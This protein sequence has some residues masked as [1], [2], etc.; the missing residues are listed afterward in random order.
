MRRL[1][2]RG[3]LA[4][5]AMMLMVA[6]ACSKDDVQPDPAPTSTGS[7]ED[8]TVPEVPDEPVE[9][10]MGVA[11]TLAEAQAGDFTVTYDLFR[12]DDLYIGLTLPERDGVIVVRYD[13][14]LPNAQL[15][16]PFWAAY[17]KDENAPK[18]VP[19]PGNADLDITV[20]PVQVVDGRMVASYRFLVKGTPIVK[21]LMTGDFTIEA[22]EGASDAD[23]LAQTSFEL[24][25]PAR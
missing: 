11:P 10:S 13:I 25:R 4:A 20:D 8:P 9:T 19:H 22:F 2:C 1:S 5:L 23:L 24:T 6:P 16:S 17:S 21:S 18:T 14:R 3:G 15:Y 12:V 7:T